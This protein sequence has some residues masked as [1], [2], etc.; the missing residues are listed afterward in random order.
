MSEE[1]EQFLRELVEGAS[2]LTPHEM[3][4]SM[5]QAIA[6][7]S[8]GHGTVAWR[9]GQ[10]IGGSIWQPRVR[11]HV[12]SNTAHV[13][14]DV[15][16]LNQDCVSIE[17]RGRGLNLTFKRTKEKVLDDGKLFSHDETSQRTIDLG[18]E[19]DP[20]KVSAEVEG[21]IMH[22]R[23]PRDIEGLAIVNINWND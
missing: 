16:G 2:R 3:V 5:E 23:C 21:G 11:W 13:F 8:A 1:S 18:I 6:A 9:D 19:I 20:S 4:E 22:I 10:P 7:I 12:D 17:A 15:A 14:V